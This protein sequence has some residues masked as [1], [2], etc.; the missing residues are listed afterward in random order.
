MTG[1]AI[2]SGSP[3]LC[4]PQPLQ[5]CVNQCCCLCL[6]ALLWPVTM[7]CFYGLN[8]TYACFRDTSI[9]QFTWYLVNLKNSISP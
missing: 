9:G 2:A 8:S 1:L 6:H 7:W 5:S 4:E 3:K